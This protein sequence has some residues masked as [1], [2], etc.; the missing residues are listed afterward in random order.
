MGMFDR[1][2]IPCPRCGQPREFQ[3]K[4]GEC[5]LADYYWPDAPVAVLRDIAFDTGWCALCRQPFEVPPLPVTCNESLD[6]CIRRI[7]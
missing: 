1:V 5:V 4:G 7:V 2:W 3:S 6:E